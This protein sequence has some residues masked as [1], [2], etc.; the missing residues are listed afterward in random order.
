MKCL[1]KNAKMQNIHEKR[2]QTLKTQAKK[3]T[4]KILW[5][6][7]QFLRVEISPSL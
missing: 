5:V 4:C 7:G 1:H 6:T 2:V 3:E